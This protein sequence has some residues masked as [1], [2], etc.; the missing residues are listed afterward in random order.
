MR[1]KGLIPLFLFLVLVFLVFWIWIDRW[2][3]QGIEQAAQ[4]VTGA[5]V[6][7]D[8]LDV[9]ITRL[10][11]SWQHMQAADP[12]STMRNVIETGMVTFKL[13]PRA[14][15]YKR[16]VIDDI[17]VSDVRSGTVRD[18]DG[19]LPERKKPKRRETSPMWEHARAEAQKQ[20]AAMPV[21]RVDPQ[22]LRASVNTDSL[23]EIAGL[24]LPGRA[25]SLEQDLRKTAEA[26]ET[27]IRDFQPEKTVSDIQYDIAALKNQQL[28]T[29]PDIMKALEKTNDIKKRIT[30]V[31]D[32]MTIRSAAARSDLAR[33]RA[34]PEQ[35][36]VWADN[37]YRALLKKA[38]LPDLTFASAGRLLFGNSV[39]RQMDRIWTVVETARRLMPAKTE[40]KKPVKTGRRGRT[41]LFTPKHGFPSFLMRHMHVSGR[42]GTGS[43][44]A[45]V[46]LSGDIRG[47]TSQPRIYGNPAVLDLSGSNADGTALSLYGLFDHTLV[48]FRDTMRIRLTGLPVVRT[49]LSI[50]D[51]FPV[52]LSSGSADM[53]AAVAAGPSSLGVTLDFSVNNASFDTGPESRDLFIQTVQQICA[54]LSTVTVRAVMTADTAGYSLRIDSNLDKELAAALRSMG[55]KALADA[56][57]RLHAH[58]SDLQ[59]KH[60]QQLSPL[61]AQIQ[62]SSLAPVLA[63]AD[64]T[65]AMN[66]VLQGF[67]EK[68]QKTLKEKSGTGNL[69][70]K[71]KDL[72]EGLLKNK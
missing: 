39:L 20:L 8:N 30:A 60:A 34:V 61:T 41:I 70:G 67:L 56:E 7:I 50:S 51:K 2:I 71:A 6:E 11:L 5:R 59:K 16:F 64:S 10:L 45:G 32:T 65:A 4:S 18:R 47:I 13:N 12:D 48:Q 37:D 49:G 42:T 72:L 14:L 55:S 63:Y 53:T 24:S 36:R 46:N 52:A 23:I 1:W 62:S 69:E 21:M 22:Q 33:I 54:R 35:L 17:Y 15:L 9:S 26:W 57:K 28:S 58:I 66:T 29:V 43:S 25:D 68:A 40:K 27:F 44:D 3:E 31:Q 19:A 38:R